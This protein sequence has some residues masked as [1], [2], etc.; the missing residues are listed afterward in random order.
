MWP[1]W[2]VLRRHISTKLYENRSTGSEPEIRWHTNRTTRKHMLTPTPSFTPLSFNARCQFTLLIYALSYPFWRS[3][4]GCVLPYANP[5]ITVG[6]SFDLRLAH[7]RPL[8]NDATMAQKKGWMYI[9]T[10]INTSTHTHAR[11]HNGNHKI[12]LLF[13]PGRD[14]TLGMVQ[15][16]RRLWAVFTRAT[17]TGSN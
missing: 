11:T 15:W 3:F 7:V 4:A 12:P 1:H 2:V 13:F 8:S 14:A 16:Y 6:I 5:S 10:Y 17:E 9:H